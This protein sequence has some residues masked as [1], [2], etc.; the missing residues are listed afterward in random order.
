M[1]NSVA[2]ARNSVA[3]VRSS[4]A[5]PRCACAQMWLLRYKCA[6]RRVGT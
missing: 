6:D 2:M 4:V 3:L 1:R 5:Q